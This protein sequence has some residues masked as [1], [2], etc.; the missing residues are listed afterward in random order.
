MTLSRP[1]ALALGA[2]LLACTAHAQLKPPRSA[3]APAAPAPAAA[4]PQAAAPA[5]KE[6]AEKENAG[7]LAAAGWLSLLDRRDWGTAWETSASLFRNS[8]PLA[9]WMDG[10]PKVR[11]PLGPLV[12]RQ[13]SN[14]I[15]KTQLE[16][17]P[18]G[19]YVSVMFVTR[20]DKREVEE[21]VTTVREA[22]G[23][24][25]VTGYSTR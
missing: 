10:I 5:N 2:A 19:D 23:R 18:D 9:A 25:R 20:F 7:K 1:L 17:R 11:E 3:A 24:W 8:V 14:S 12:E 6:A 16:G 22:D 13:P 4:P 15:Y 21:I